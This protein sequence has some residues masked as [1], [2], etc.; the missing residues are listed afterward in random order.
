[1]GQ[2]TISKSKEDYLKAIFIV[3]R[4]NGAC[5]V[6]DIARQMGGT[7][8]STSVALI[9]LEEAGYL[10]RDDWRVLLTEEG[11]Q[12]AEITYERN[13]FFIKKKFL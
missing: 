12:I 5:R 9:K 4:K 8:A 6:T 3:I 13:N 10:Y 2:K 11:K 1:M 7:K